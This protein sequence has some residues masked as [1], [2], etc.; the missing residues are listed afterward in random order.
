MTSRA[1]GRTSLRPRDRGG[2]LIESL[3]LGVVLLLPIAFVVVEF[4]EIQRAAIG[5]S[6]ASREGGRAFVT[7]SSPSEANERAE[8]AIRRVLSLHR[9]DPGRS[10][11]SIDGRLTRGGEVR[12][13]VEY[14]TPK[15]PV[16]LIGEIPGITLRS[17]HLE[18]VDRHRWIKGG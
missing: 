11:V 3:L 12:V 5:I 17:A 2:S 15:V 16:P 4:G 14:R 10:V 9:L 13:H 7:A 18:Q 8:L 6:A 1:N